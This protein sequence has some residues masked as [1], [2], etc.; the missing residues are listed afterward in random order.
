MEA[1][2]VTANARVVAGRR[3]AQVC[4]RSARTASALRMQSDFAELQPG[5][6]G[7]KP[8]A[9]DMVKVSD[10]GV[11]PFPDDKN[12]VTKVGSEI[13]EGLAEE[14]L[15]GK[16]SGKEIEE[17][18]KGGKAGADLITAF[19]GKK[20]EKKTSPVVIKPVGD[21][22]ESSG[23]AV[24][25]QEAQGLA[26]PMAG[27]PGFVPEAFQTAKV[28]TLGISPFPDDRN[29]VTKVGGIQAVREAAERARAG[30]K[31][32]ELEAEYKG[33]SN[34]LEASLK[35]E[36]AAKKASASGLPDYLMPLPE[37]TPRRGMTWKNG[38]RK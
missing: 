18:L 21:E 6:P 38:P 12:A 37:D 1:F 31:S 22:S 28:S 32:K 20:D 8:R 23:F 34:S 19:T 5:D 11:S 36:D 17:E 2:V 4:T 10:L 16:R 14:V 7:Y 24:K 35:K 27:E 25:G 15:S 9:R 30:I 3:H 33:P 26:A 29:S 13:L